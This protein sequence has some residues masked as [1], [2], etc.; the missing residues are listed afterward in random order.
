MQSHSLIFGASHWRLTGIRGG[1]ELILRREI[2]NREN[3]VSRDPLI[4]VIWW[5]LYLASKFVLC[6]YSRISSPLATRN[7]CLT[8]LRCIFRTCVSYLACVQPW[9]PLSPGFC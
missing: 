2:L 7:V 4:L 9:A 5:I 1:W 8:V 3:T 6:K